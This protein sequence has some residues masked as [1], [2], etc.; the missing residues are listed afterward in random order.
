MKWLKIVFAAFLVVGIF[1]CISSVAYAAD[2]PGPGLDVDI[3]VAGDNPNVDLDIFGDNPQVW[4][5]GHNLN[6]PVA[7]YTIR[8]GGGV[9]IGWVNQRIGEELAPFQSWVSE[10]GD[11]VELTVEGLARVILLVQEHSSEISTLAESLDS[12]GH[13]ASLMESASE[14]RMSTLESQQAQITAEVN[15]LRDAHNRILAIIIGAFSLVVIGLVAGFVL[16]W[17]RT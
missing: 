3:V 13:V 12:Q 11:T 5:N 16:L 1:L 2:P 6:D 9:D 8:G 17:R 10:Y 7:V 14:Q 4:I 15:D